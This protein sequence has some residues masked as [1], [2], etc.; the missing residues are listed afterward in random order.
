MNATDAPYGETAPTEMS[1][2]LAISLVVLGTGGLALMISIACMCVQLTKIK[3]K[4]ES[5][6]VEEL[7]PMAVHI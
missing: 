7:Q 2:L 6:Q 4:R 3:C 5:T 1:L